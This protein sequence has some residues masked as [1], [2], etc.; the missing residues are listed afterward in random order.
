MNVVIGCPIEGKGLLIE[1]K[2]IKG[3]SLREA[4]YTSYK[5]QE[6]MFLINR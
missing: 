1:G 5:I 6:N 3:A 4:G 2:L